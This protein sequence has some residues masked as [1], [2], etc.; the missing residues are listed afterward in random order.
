MMT[1]YNGG[2]NL[3]HTKSHCGKIS[4]RA[5]KSVYLDLQQSKHSLDLAQ[6]VELYFASSFLSFCLIG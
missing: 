1:L 5:C 4:K 2:C 6:S 3:G